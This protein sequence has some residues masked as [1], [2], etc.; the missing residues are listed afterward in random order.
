MNHEQLAHDALCA[1][2]S[3]IVAED[4]PWRKIEARVGR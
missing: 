2:F 4:E 3:S 1:L